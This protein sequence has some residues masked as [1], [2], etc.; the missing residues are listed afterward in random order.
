MDAQLKFENEKL[1]RE[2]LEWRQ[3]VDKLRTH[4]AALERQIARTPEI[5]ELGNRLLPAAAPTPVANVQLDWPQIKRALL[6]DADV[7]AAV[8]TIIASRPEIRIEV[9]PKTITFDGDSAKGRLARMVANG[10]LNQPCKP[11]VVIKEFVRTGGAIH[12]S[13]LSDYLSDFVSCGFLLREGDTYVKAPGLKVTT[14]E[15]QA[16]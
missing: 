3:E 13:R 14:K 15:L 1:E 2:N 16:V 8:A 10:L 4:L 6:A 11:G 5:V 7:L 9:T 12:P